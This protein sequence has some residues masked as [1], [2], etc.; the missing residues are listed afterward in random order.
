MIG[1]PD[2]LRGGRPPRVPCGAHQ[3]RYRAAAL[4]FRVA[5]PFFAE[6]ERWAAVRLADAF[7]PFLPPLRLGAWFSFLPRPEPDFLPPCVSALTVAQARRAASP[8]PTPR[9]S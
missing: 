7:P 4:R 1:V 9:L 6:A 8:S 5:A 2:A 3:Q